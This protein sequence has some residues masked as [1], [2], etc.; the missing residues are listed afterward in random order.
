V[1]AGL[2]RSGAR[3]AA[4]QGEVVRLR[5]AHSDLSFSVTLADAPGGADSLCTM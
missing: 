4:G 2:T 1:E 3:L 5:A